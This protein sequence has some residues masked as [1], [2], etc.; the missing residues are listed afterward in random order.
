M[1]FL[2]AL[3][4][5]PWLFKRLA[6]ALSLKRIHKGRKNEVQSRGERA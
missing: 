2:F 5:H 3:F 6:W 1:G 4:V